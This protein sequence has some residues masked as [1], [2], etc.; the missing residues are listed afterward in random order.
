MTGQPLR[1][2]LLT[3]ADKPRVIS[4]YNGGYWVEK[5]T[6]DGPIVETKHT[7]QE[8]INLASWWGAVRKEATS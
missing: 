5:M 4:N 8:A 6:T 1:K 2:R 3:L 7:F